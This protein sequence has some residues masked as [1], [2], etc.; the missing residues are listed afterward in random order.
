MEYKF[1]M[2]FTEDEINEMRTYLFNFIND[3]C[4]ERRPP[5]DRNFVLM[6]HDGNLYDWQFY[7]RRML[8]N[9]RYLTYT[10]MLF[11]TRY[12]DEFKQYPFQ[13]AGLETGS[14][15]LIVGL[16]MTAPSF[17]VNV[18]AFSI[19][20]DRK[21]YGLY[22]RMEGIVTND[23]IMLVD[24]MCNSKNT[25]LIAKRYCEEEELPIYHKAF[26]VVNKN[27][28]ETDSKNYDKHIGPSLQVDSLFYIDEFDLSYIQYH[29]KKSNIGE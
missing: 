17:G 27:I 21:R 18:N 9:S 28:L 8:F 15:P 4:I 23:P 1:K 11:W 5:G 10:G 25:M 7:L 3:N 6:T 20:K 13:I 24:D 26:S 29:D 14:T 12:A 19:R 22:N 16:A 2:T